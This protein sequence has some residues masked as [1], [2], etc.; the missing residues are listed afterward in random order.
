M[1]STYREEETR[2]KNERNVDRQDLVQV[3]LLNTGVK[4]NGK[5]KAVV[6]LTKKYHDFLE[7]IS[8]KEPHQYKKRPDQQRDVHCVT[9]T[10]KGR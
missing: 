1:I 2:K 7:D 9:N 3:Y 6:P 10:T 4:L 5:R 8:P